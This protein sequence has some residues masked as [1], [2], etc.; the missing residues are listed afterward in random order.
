MSKVGGK[1][2]KRMSKGKA[3]ENTH[4]KTTPL[5][6]DPFEQYGCVVGLPGNSHVEIMTEEGT[7]Y[8]GR[9]SGRMRKLKRDNTVRNFSI[10]LIGVNEYKTNGTNSCDIL[11]IYDDPEVN[12]LKQNPDVHIENLL[13]VQY[14]GLFNANGGGGSSSSK[15]KKQADDMV[16][17]TNMCEAE[18]D[19]V[20]KQ[21]LPTNN[22]ATI[23]GANAGEDD[24]DEG[25]G[26]C[27]DFN[28]DDI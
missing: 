23:R 11:Y 15:N 17:F 6:Q 19:A 24:D 28:I 13:N 3:V 10:V 25:G 16:D 26:G 5:S 27:G 4:Q 18:I 20:P 9:I 1:Y 12:K 2:T 7:K 8:R 14:N 21:R 22:E